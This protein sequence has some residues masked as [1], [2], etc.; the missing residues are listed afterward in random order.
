MRDLDADGIKGV[1]FAEIA[2]RSLKVEQAEKDILG[3]ERAIKERQDREAQQNF[4][5]GCQ[6]CKGGQTQVQ[7]P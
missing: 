6:G 5:P 1:P 7:R 4:R 3:K 2:D